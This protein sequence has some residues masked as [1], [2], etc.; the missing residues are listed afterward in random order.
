[1]ASLS[2][3]IHRGYRK[4]DGLVTKVVES[5]FPAVSRNVTFRC[6]A[7]LAVDRFTFMLNFVDQSYILL[8]F[9]AMQWKMW[10]TLYSSFE[11]SDACE[12]VPQNVC[13]NA[14]VCECV[15]KQ[16]NQKA[17]DARCKT[18]ALQIHLMTS[19]I[20]DNVSFDIKI[21]AHLFVRIRVNVPQNQG[22]RKSNS[23]AFSIPEILTHVSWFVILT[24]DFYVILSYIWR[25][26]NN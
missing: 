15:A 24:P 21:S 8:Q 16:L 20:P 26:K 2:L 1:M 4:V 11:I 18:L 7:M 17:K 10:D 5:R 23:S 14:R 22:N 6:N 25:R 12:H 13:G 3:Q 19:S 9:I